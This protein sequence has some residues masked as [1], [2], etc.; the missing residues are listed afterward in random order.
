MKEGLLVR[1]SGADLKPPQAAAVKSRGGERCEK[2]GQDSGRHGRERRAQANR[3][4]SVEKRL[5]DVRTEGGPFLRDQLGG[6]LRLPER[7]PACRRREARPGCRMERENLCSAAPMARRQK[8]QAAPTARA[9]VPIRSAGAEQPVMV[10]KGP[11]MG[12]ERRGCVVQP[13][14]LANWKREE[15]ADKAKPFKIPKRSNLWRR[16][17]TVHQPLRRA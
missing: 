11:V 9:R 10:S 14:P 8:P 5:G 17:T 12:L 2:P 4:R 13:W 7:H 3:C 16:A 15:L 1:Q 6:C